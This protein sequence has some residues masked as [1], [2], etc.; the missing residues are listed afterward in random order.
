MPFYISFFLFLLTL[1]F[2]FLFFRTI[3]PLFT[4]DFV[5]F[6][7]FVPDCSLLCTSEFRL[8]DWYDGGVSQPQLV[9][10]DLIEALFPTGNYTMTYFR[11]VAKVAYLVIHTELD[12]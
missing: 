1:F 3:Y 6:Y 8:K 5:N 11:N 9:L 12:H 4:I 10:A 7:G 2:L